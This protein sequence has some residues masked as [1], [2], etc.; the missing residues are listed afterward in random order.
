M[1]LAALR[2]SIRKIAPAAVPGARRA[3]GGLPT[4]FDDLDR[5]LRTGGFSRGRITE[6]VGAP[7]SGKMALALRAIAEQ[8]RAGSLATL[9]DPHVYPPAAAALGVDLARLLLV[10]PPSLSAKDAV[11]AAEILARSRAFSLIAI[12][13]PAGARPSAALARRLRAAAQ[14]TSAAL[15]VIADRGGAVEGAAARIEI[16]HARGS[17]ERRACAVVSKGSTTGGAQRAELALPSIRIDDAPP[18]A[19][20]P[21]TTRLAPGVEA[22]SKAAGGRA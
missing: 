13:L 20:W 5:Q 21:K 22:G 15:L 14:R 11:R 8:T 16:A 9:L 4:G 10:R 7:S 1:E 12:A 6:I 18:V 17:S 2:E 19:V 3:P